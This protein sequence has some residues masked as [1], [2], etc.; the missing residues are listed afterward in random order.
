[1]CFREVELQMKNI[2]RVCIRKVAIQRKNIARVCFRE[3]ELL[4]GGREGAARPVPV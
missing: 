4:G 1:M 3:V 2:A